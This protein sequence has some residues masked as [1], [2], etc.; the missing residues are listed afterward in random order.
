M[1]APPGDV[2]DRLER[3][4]AHAPTAVAAPEV[5]WAQGRRRQRRAWAAVAACAVVLA[6]LGAA[7]L[8][9]VL[10]LT[11]PP[12]AVSPG[13]SGLVLPDHVRE[14]GR[15]E[16]EFPAAPGPLTAVGVGSRSGWLSTRGAWWG[17][18]G[19]TGESRFL[20]L[21]DAS[22]EIEA[23]P[24]LSAD[25]TR[26]AYWV[27]GETSETL[28]DPDGL[29]P[30]DALPIVG[31]AVLDLV[32][33]DV[34]RWTTDSPRGKAPVGMAWAGDVLWWSSGDWDEDSTTTQGGYAVVNRTWDLSTDERTDLPRGSA[35]GRL[36]LAPT[37]PSPGGFLAATR[38]GLRTVTARGLEPT[39]RLDRNLLAQESTMPAIAPDGTRVAGIE[40]VDPQV[41][42]VAPHRL[43]VG[44]LAPGG[45]ARLEPVAGIE[46]HAVLGWR[47]AREVVVL[48]D[49]AASVVDVGTGEGR[50]LLDFAGNVPDFAG[51]AWSGDLVDAPDAPLAPDPRL[52]AFLVGVA[53]VVGTSVWRSVRRRRGHP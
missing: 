31:V 3:L 27:T 5:L 17:V 11:D 52:V 45:V 6:G 32:T 23:M 40:E 19:T 36:S 53:A 2:V 24:A 10:R 4:S 50:P 7:V 43:L 26:L 39:T 18:S 1:S 28:P 8:P 21:P 12:V 51:D 20:D 16:P 35:D 25:G 22:L 41:F 30:D 15:W 13:S 38:Q 9:P 44:D 46:A 34:R 48:T 14:P 49:R 33:G 29:H 37:A 47:S 42:D